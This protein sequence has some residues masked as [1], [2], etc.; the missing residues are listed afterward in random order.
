MH[1][2]MSP[3]RQPVSTDG[4]AAISTTVNSARA[5]RGAG[6]ARRPHELRLDR[7]RALIGR[8]Q[9]RE[10]RVGDD[11]RDLRGVVEAED[12]H[13]RRIERDLRHRRQHAH[14]RLDQRLDRA[15]AG[16]RD[17]SATPTTSAIEKPANRR[18]SVIATLSEKCGV[19]ELL[20]Q[21]REHRARRR[22]QDGGRDAR[23]PRCPAT[24]R[25][26]SA[27]GSDADGDVADGAARRHVDPTRDLV[28]RIG[29]GRR[30]ACAAAR[31]AHRS[32]SRARR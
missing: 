28:H 20:D 3:M 23:T 26:T 6:R 27:I 2:M 17:P 4:S 21:P 25:C 7:R 14:Q 24:A 15:A 1:E 18:N 19:A 30:G 12:Q 11:Q 5:L 9:D 10:H 29:P 31:T 16:R 32:Q 22:Q 8:E 13:E